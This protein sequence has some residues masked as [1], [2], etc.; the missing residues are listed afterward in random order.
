MIVIFHTEIHELSITWSMDGLSS[1]LVLRQFLMRFL[2][3]A[4]TLDH[5][6]LG[7]SYCPDLIL[8]FMPGDIG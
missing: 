3:S 1:G 2:H 4:D 7:N 8:F 6:L 5:S